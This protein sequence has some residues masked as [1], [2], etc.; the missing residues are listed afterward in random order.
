MTAG[1]VIVGGGQAASSAAAKI[2]ELDPDIPVTM[3]CGEN[4]LPYQR[5]PLSKKYLSGEMPLDRLVLRPDD[6]FDEQNVAVERGRFASRI[7]CSGKTI[8]LDNGKSLAY[9][10][11]LLATGARERRLPT[12]MGGDLTGVH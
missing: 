1:L 3:I 10:K 11:L 7:D 4:T 9:D 12:S 6:W 8:T 2:R 5:P